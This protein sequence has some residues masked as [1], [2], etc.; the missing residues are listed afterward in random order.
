MKF[1]DLVK[2]QYYV[3][4]DGGKRTYALKHRSHPNDRYS[5]YI[6]LN[7]SAYDRGGDFNSTYDFQPA[8]TEEI[9]WLDAC[10]AADRWVPKPIDPTLKNYSIC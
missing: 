5:K 3:R 9:A 10:I 6:T 2:D 4:M 8:T 1:E 7:S